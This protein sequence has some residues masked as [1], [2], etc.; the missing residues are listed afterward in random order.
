MC[1]YIAMYVCV[2]THTIHMCIGILCVG[3]NY[4][5]SSSGCWSDQSGC[6]ADLKNIHFLLLLKA[7]LIL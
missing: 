6:L 3:D 4:N 1:G 5:S 7:L 2:W